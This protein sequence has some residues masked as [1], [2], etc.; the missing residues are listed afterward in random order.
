MVVGFSSLCSA[1]SGD[2]LLNL[3]SN[4]GLLQWKPRNYL[5]Y[6]YTKWRC[7][8]DQKITNDWSPRTQQLQVQLC[9]VLWRTGIWRCP[10]GLIDSENW[11]W[12]WVNQLHSI[13]LHLPCIWWHWLC[14]T[15]NTI[16]FKLGRSLHKGQMWPQECRIYDGGAALEVAAY[17]GILGVLWQK[18]R[19]QYLW[20]GAKIANCYIACTI[21]G[22]LLIQSVILMA[23]VEQ[24][25]RRLCWFIWFVKCKS[26]IIGE[27]VY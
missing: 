5:Y 15:R 20:H 23:F 1:L 13:F 6:K 2:S 18:R 25:H 11:F 16:P 12:I 8:I 17:N 24:T 21:H 9:A 22:K 7:G 26:S 10:P 14:F 19:H 3:C 27:L 4:I